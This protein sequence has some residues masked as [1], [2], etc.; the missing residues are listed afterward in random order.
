MKQEFIEFLNALMAACPEV[1]EAQMTENVKNYIDAL[2]TQTASKDKVMTEKGQMLLKH[3]QD[4]PDT[5]MWKAHDLADALGLASRSVSGSMRKLVA[6]EFVE[7]IGSNP[8]VY[9]LTEKGKNFDINSIADEN[10][11]D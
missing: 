6:D 9:T 10:N 8:F 3:M 4:N 1:V 7:K 5:I 2:M 11:K